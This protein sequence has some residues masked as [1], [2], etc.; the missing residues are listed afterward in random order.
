M[1]LT[2]VMGW[3]II[4][5]ASKSGKCLIESARPDL[6][7]RLCVSP[8]DSV[9]AK[10]KGS[11]NIENS[12]LAGLVVLESK[13]KTGY[14][15]NGYWAVKIGNQERVFPSRISAAV[16]MYLGMGLKDAAGTT[17]TS[18]AQEIIGGIAYSK[19]NGSVS[20]AIGKSR[21]QTA[22]AAANGP[23]TVGGKGST[24]GCVSATS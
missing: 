19:A 24:P 3:N 18:Y 9:A 1:G 23:T 22:I 14:A 4:R 11:A 21:P 2:Q 7:G 13:Y 8:G 16:S 17:P 10:L 15:K 12:I 6:A 5:G 20:P